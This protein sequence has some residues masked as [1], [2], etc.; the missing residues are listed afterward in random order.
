[1]KTNLSHT[2]LPMALHGHRMVQWL[3]SIMTSDDYRRPCMAQA[4]FHCL[5]LCITINSTK[6][7]YL[8]KKGILYSNAKLRQF[9]VKYLMKIIQFWKKKFLF[10]IT[11]CKNHLYSFTTLAKNGFSN[12]K[13]INC[14]GP[15]IDISHLTRFIDW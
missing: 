4:I 6:I 7:W 9:C 12:W 2:R 1:M 3:H 5:G 11:F 15:P 8:G 13:R 10:R 14:L